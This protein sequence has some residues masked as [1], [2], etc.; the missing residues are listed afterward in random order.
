MPKL[1]RLDAPEVL[2]HTMIRGI[3]RRN[4]FRDDRDRE[5]FLNR[6]AKLL[7][8]AQTACYAWV[9]IANHAHFLFRTGKVPLAT[10]VRLFQG[11][12]TLLKGGRLSAGIIVISLSNNF[13]SFLRASP[14]S[15]PGVYHVARGTEKH[16]PPKPML[17]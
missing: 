3:E 17:T 15:R 6:L 1:A 13:L 5:D 4:I 10:L 9:L 16:M 12:D 7:P 11:W 8:E 2:Q 14:F